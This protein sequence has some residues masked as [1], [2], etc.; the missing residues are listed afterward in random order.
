M[1]CSWH[2]PSPLRASFNYFESQVIYLYRD[3]SV[4][5]SLV[6]GVK[7]TSSTLASVRLRLLDDVS[8]ECSVC[9]AHPILYQRHRQTWDG[10]SGSWD[11]SSYQELS[12]P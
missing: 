1:V 5:K 7:T 6:S 4:Q 2:V 3:A 9:L 10:A 12:P 11:E 8:A